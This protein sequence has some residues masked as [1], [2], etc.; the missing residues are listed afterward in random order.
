[1][2]KSCVVLNG[3]VINIG[4]WDYQKE[5]VGT[6][7]VIHNPMSEGAI[8]EERD[9]E[10]SDDR[11]WYQVGVQAPKTA[12]ELLQEENTMLQLAL[13]ELAEAQEADKTETQLALAELAEII[14]GGA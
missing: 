2:M 9:F 5:M 4:E 3:R 12:I 7:E 13:V 1:M 8:I 14:A 10:Y 11:G 6:E